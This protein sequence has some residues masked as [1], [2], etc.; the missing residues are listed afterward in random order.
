MM[1]AS[2]PSCVSS[3]P[4]RSS[5][6]PMKCSQECC[7]SA[8]SHLGSVMQPFSCLLLVDASF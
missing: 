7:S 4:G 2:L 3:A 5:T 8:E 6:T 1:P